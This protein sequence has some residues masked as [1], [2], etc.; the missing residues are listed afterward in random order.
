MVHEHVLKIIAHI[1]PFDPH[2][3][4]APRTHTVHCW[5]SQRACLTWRRVKVERLV[6][7]VRGTSCQPSQGMPGAPPVKSGTRGKTVFTIQALSVGPAVQTASDQKT[8]K[9]TDSCKIE[10]AAYRATARIQPLI[11]CVTSSRPGGRTASH[12]R[13]KKPRTA[14]QHRPALLPCPAARLH[15]GRW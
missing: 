13:R 6:P 9:P 14:T 11:R 15:A 12:I 7:P 2:G 3:R 8:A 1:S 4:N 5:C 10:I